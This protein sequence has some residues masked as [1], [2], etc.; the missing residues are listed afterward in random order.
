MLERSIGEFARTIVIALGFIIVGFTTGHWWLAIT[1]ALSL[2]LIWVLLQQ[3]R[4]DHWLSSGRRGPSPTTFGIWG[5]I[6]DDFYRLQ[7]RHRKEKV[8][9]H[10]MLRRV[11][12]STSALREGIVALEQDGNLAWWNP[13]AGKM[14]RLQSGDAGQPLINFVRDPC[15]VS[16]IQQS[17]DGAELREPLTMSA[18]GDDERRLQLEVTHYGLGEALVVV[19]DIT[20]L[21]NLEQIR[22]DFVANVSHELR[23]PL[24]VIAGYLET[25]EASGQAP[26]NWLRPLGQMREQAERMTGLVNDLLLLARL[27]TSERNNGREQVAVQLLIEEVAAEARALSRGEHRISVQCADDD[28]MRGNAGQLHSAFANLVFNAVRYSPAG[29]EIILRW[30]HNTEGGHFSV[31]DS[32]IGI[33]PIHIPRLT[34][35]FYRVDEGRSRR[36]GGT[37]LG[38]AIVKHVLLRHSGKLNIHSVPGEGSTFTLSFPAEKFIEISEA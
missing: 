34:E 12:D 11:Q 20:R 25:L 23:T 13:T 6:A 28:V 31:S 24:T 16:Y 26:E 36:T 1:L 22:Q 4:F 19:R 15:F 17:P 18:P 21:H 29:G 9:L 27:E 8:K 38:L 37:G 10:A 30:E 5:D 7:R 33:E 2:Y 32:G 35:R 3:K 14:L